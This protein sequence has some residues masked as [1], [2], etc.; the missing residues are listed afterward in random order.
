MITSLTTITS[1]HAKLQSM[2]IGT[3][4]GAEVFVQGFIAPIGC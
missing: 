3:F 2:I 1:E 4:A